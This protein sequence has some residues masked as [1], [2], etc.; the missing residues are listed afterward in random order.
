VTDDLPPHDDD[1]TPF[2]LNQPYAELLEDLVDVLNAPVDV[3]QHP[4]FPLSSVVVPIRSRP[5]V[6]DPAGP[7]TPNHLSDLL[8]META[9]Q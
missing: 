8:P 6:I 3:P 4:N 7:S 2:E 9:R 5:Q 1:V